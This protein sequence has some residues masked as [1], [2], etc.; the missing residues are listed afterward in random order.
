MSMSKRDEYMKNNFPVVCYYYNG[1]PVPLRDDTG[2]EVITP[3]YGGEENVGEVR[4]SST[5]TE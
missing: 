4:D 2:E 1:V 5:E 3:N